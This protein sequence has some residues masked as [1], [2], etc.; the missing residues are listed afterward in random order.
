M[1]PHSV[2]FDVFD[3]ALPAHEILDG[4]PCSEE[5]LEAFLRSISL[6]PGATALMDWCAKRGV[7]FRVLSD[8]FDYNLDRLQELLGVSFEYDANRLRYEG[9]V[10][11]IAAGPS[12]AGCFC[13]TGVC[14]ARC[15]DELRA[16]RPEA[17]TVHIGNGRVSDLCGA[18]AADVAF[19]KDSL[20][21]ELDR[22]GAAFE[23]FETLHDVIPRLETLLVRLPA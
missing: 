20:A 1:H 23:R 17:I 7:P 11:K 10:W 14:K 22:L 5:Q 2:A 19:A 21:E 13:G 4:L 16:A 9:H 8:G 15:I 3:R 12:D 18:L 6:D